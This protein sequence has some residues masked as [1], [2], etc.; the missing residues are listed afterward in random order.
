MRDFGWQSTAVGE[1]CRS[2]GPKTVLRP[3]AITKRNYP[4]INEFECL[5]SFQRESEP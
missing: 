2:L 3:L 1:V 4:S 5:E